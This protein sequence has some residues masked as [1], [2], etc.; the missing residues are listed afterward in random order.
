MGYLFFSLGLLFSLWSAVYGPRSVHAQSLPPVL[1]ILE[2]E[3]QD[4]KEIERLIQFHWHDKAWAALQNYSEQDPQ[5]LYL[6]G[7]SRYGKKEFAAALGFFERVPPSKY[8]KEAQSKIAQT[9]ARQ[10]R[11]DASL[12]LFTKL[13]PQQRG[14]RAQNQMRWLAFKT[15]LEAKQ[16]RKGLKFLGPLSGPR[17]HWWR[18]W[19]YYRQGNLRE[20]LRQWDHIPKRRSGG[21]YPRAFFWKAQI[22]QD[23]G[24]PQ[25]AAQLRADLIERYPQNYYSLLAGETPAV[26]GGD[27]PPFFFKIRKEAKKAKLDPWLVVSLIRQES[28]FRPMTVSSAGAMGLMQIIPQ[29]ALRL[30]GESKRMKFKWPEMFEPEVSIELGVFYLKF[31]AGLFGGEPHLMIAAYNA[32]EEAVSRW[33]ALRKNDPL[34]VFI[35]E[36]PYDQTQNYVQRVLTNYWSYSWLYRGEVRMR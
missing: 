4:L 13:I 15:A 20:A 19:C 21:F 24:Q 36:I 3:P 25:K 11:Y 33:L 16:Y 6:K 32:G 27:P 9:L 22:Y 12:Q 1:Q 10:E 28:G 30:V 18:G 23:S 14:G 8:F 35:E 17:A 29:T 7:L 5:V 26:N 31:L 34:A 2:K